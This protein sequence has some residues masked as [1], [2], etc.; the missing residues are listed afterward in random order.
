VS[1]ISCR[2]TRRAGFAG[3]VFGSRRDHDRRAK[4]AAVQAAHPGWFCWPGVIPPL[5]Y[6]RRSRSSPPMVVRAASP[7]ALA[8]V[9]ER[10]EV[11]RPG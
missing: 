2:I 11:G 9:I 1:Q 6:A 8:E 10:A 7:E 5:V 3:R 4:T